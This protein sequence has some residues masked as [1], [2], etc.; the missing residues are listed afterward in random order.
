MSDGPASL[1]LASLIGADSWEA[2][3]LPGG[4]GTARWCPIVEF[5][6][7]ANALGFTP[8]GEWSWAAWQDD[9]WRLFPLDTDAVV[10]V[11]PILGIPLRELQSKVRQ[12]AARLGLPGQE[13]VD[14]LPIT[15]IIQ[16]ASELD[17]TTGLGMQWSGWR[18]SVLRLH[19]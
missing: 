18:R 15:T 11:L 9:R 16:A 17:R 1:E 19:F 10:G 13:V 2:A 7:L 12:S 4:Q 8:T 5:G 6:E 3:E 14:D